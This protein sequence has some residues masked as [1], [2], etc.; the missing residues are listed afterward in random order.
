[1]KQS[2]VIK[3]LFLSTTL[4]GAM[5]IVPHAM[6]SDLNENAVDMLQPAGGVQLKSIRK[7]ASS[8]IQMSETYVQSAVVEGAN[9]L[10]FVTAV[11]LTDTMESI[12]Y[13]RSIAGM[14]D[15]TKN[16]EVFYKSI[17]AGESTYYYDGTNLVTEKQDNGFYFACYTIKIESEEH[18]NSNISCY[19]TINE[20]ESSTKVTSSFVAD[21]SEGKCVSKDTDGNKIIRAEHQYGDH[22]DESYFKAPAT[23]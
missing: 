14:N 12:V 4:L 21:Q 19:L 8:D 17:N 23:C 18:L 3:K 20:T 6:Q 13:H 15:A 1:M 22:V 2:S 10:R 11:K 9:Y 5:I 16:V 7:E